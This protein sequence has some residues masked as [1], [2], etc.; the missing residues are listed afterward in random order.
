VQPA[1]EA[2]SGFGVPSGYYLLQINYPDGTKDDFRIALIKPAATSKATMKD[3]V[4]PEP[5]APPK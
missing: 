2:A 1:P 5:P 3:E 4:Q